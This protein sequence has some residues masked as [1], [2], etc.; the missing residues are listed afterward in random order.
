MQKAEPAAGA[1]LFV[2]D[3]CHRGGWIGR[4]PR[5]RAALFT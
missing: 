3:A 2:Q 5:R 1:P 4:K